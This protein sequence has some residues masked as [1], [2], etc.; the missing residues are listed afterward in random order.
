M[1]VFV[2]PGQGSQF[3]GMGKE[4]FDEFPDLMREAD[5]V[6][7]YSVRDICM[8][9]GGARIARTRYAQPAIYTVNVLT[10][11]RFQRKSPLRPSYLLGHSLGEYCA[12]YAAGAFDFA[13]GLEL[14]AR[15]GELMAEADSGAMAAVVG[16]TAEQVEAATPGDGVWVA[17]LNTPHQ[18]VIS[19]GT[20]QIHSARDD[21]LA[22][23]ATRYVVLP[24]SGAF[25]SPL[26]A[27]AQARFAEVLAAAALRDLRI[28]V[29][30]NLSGELHTD[31]GLRA[32]LA[33][34]ISA[35]VRWADSIRLLLHR[36]E[37][38]FIE[39]GARRVLT[40]MIEKIAA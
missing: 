15:R 17:N 33:A 38:R 37:T 12:L 40:P 1:P 16:L 27:A 22:A 31:A 13:T 8:E 3:P 4:L 29:V 19:G 20:E 10:Y 11:L 2:F 32:S 18:V 25:H 5:A 6:L 34:Q 23:G 7:G 26:M 24:V 39:T 9:P 14:V 28:P 21:F 36:G 30:A 35:P